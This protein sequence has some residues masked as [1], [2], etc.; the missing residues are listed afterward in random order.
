MDLFNQTDTNFI[1]IFLDK[2]L[3]N[4]DKNIIPIIISYCFYETFPR[5]IV[6]DYLVCNKC[7]YIENKDDGLSKCS[8]CELTLCNS[9]ENDSDTEINHC[10]YCCQYFCDNCKKINENDYCNDCEYFD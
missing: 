2:L 3:K 5:Q 7:Q 8:I 9:C 6:N 10:E 1:Y 4:N